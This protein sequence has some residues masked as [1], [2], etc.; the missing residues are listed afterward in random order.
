VDHRSAAEASRISNATALIQKFREDCELRGLS[1]ITCHIYPE[2]VKAFACFLQGDLRTVDK[3]ALKSYLSYLRNERG[4][5]RS[6]IERML[7]ALASFYDFLEEEGL[8]SFN[9]VTSM[10]KR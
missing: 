3:N 5:K 2:T 8:V 7:A 10:R 4:L 1:P 6:S 9:P